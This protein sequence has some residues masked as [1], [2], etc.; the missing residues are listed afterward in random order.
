MEE[1][2]LSF[3]CSSPEEDQF[4]ASPSGRALGRARARVDNSVYLAAFEASPVSMSEFP[5]GRTPALPVPFAHAQSPTS[6]A[7]WFSSTNGE[8]QKVKHEILRKIAISGVADSAEEDGP[9]D[10][11]LSDDV[12]SEAYAFPSSDSDHKQGV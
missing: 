3:A 6:Q 5:A 2:R 4:S 12:G 9:D 10:E 7:Q 1:A 11:L 8:L